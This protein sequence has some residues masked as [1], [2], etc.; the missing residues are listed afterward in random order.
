MTIRALVVTVLA[1]FGIKRNKP[2]VP[3]ISIEETCGKITVDPIE[4]D[5]TGGN[6]SLQELH[7]I[8]QIVKNEKPSTI[9]EIGTFNGRTTLNLDYFSPEGASVY[10]L[11]LPKKDLEKA[12]FGIEEGDRKYVEKNTI[13]DRYQ[14][15]ANKII[16]LYGD[17]ATFDFSPYYGMID[18][19]F[20]DGAHSEPYAK[21]D[22]E[23]AFKLLRNGGVILWHDYGVWRGV[24][25]VLNAY[26]KHDTR[27]KGIRHI[28]G[29][30]LVYYKNESEKHAHHG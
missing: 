10:T 1:F 12:K 23:V 28:D 26:Y 20:V 16:Q 27:C 4:K 5:E 14:K 22:T 6:I 15:K 7:I 17:S 8:S 18:I 2:I 9:F 13:G 11:D 30:S 24:T 19:V 21:N 25:K 3:K 29:T